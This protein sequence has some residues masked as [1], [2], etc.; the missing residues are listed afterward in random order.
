VTEAQATQALEALEQRAERALDK[1]ET[2]WR[3]FAAAL[4]EIKDTKAYLETHDTWGE[5]VRERWNKS[6]DTAT[7]ILNA[8]RVLTQLHN[9]LLAEDLPAPSYNAA[10]ILATVKDPEGQAQVWRE[11]TE[12]GEPM[13]RDRNALRNKVREFKGESTVGQVISPEDLEEINRENALTPEEDFMFKILGEWQRLKKLDPEKV[14][15]ELYM[16]DD[17]RGRIEL[18]AARKIIAWYE[19]FTDALTKQRSQGLR[20]VE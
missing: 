17:E 20:A 16:E 4:Q 13:D 14:A 1:A 18:E 7:R 11:F 9:T 8:N 3:E 2:G 19:S 10:Q 6:G 12:S 5:Y 15:E